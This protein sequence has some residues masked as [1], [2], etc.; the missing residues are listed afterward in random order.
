MVL[1]LNIHGNS[2]AHSTLYPKRIKVSNIE[3]TAIAQFNEKFYELS[4]KH[5]V[6]KKAGAPK[7][8]TF[9]EIVRDLP[10]HVWE[11]INFFSNDLLMELLS[12]EKW[13]R[14]PTRLEVE[15]DGFS[16]NFAAS[17]VRKRIGSVISKRPA[18][19]FPVPVG[20]SASH[21]LQIGLLLFTNPKRG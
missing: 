14:P 18:I 10:P 15:R 2:T 7:P 1:K 9:Q 4:K 19:T 20:D 17:P 8:P 16:P 13:G 6:A 12:G 5:R 21:Q 11:E 3:K